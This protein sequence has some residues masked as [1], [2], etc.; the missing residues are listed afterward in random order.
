MCICFFIE[1]V[2]I[3]QY[4]FDVFDMLLPYVI[5]HSSE[6]VAFVELLLYFQLMT[7]VYNTSTIVFF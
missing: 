3:K 7:C 1:V 2:L 4:L 5:I 6:I